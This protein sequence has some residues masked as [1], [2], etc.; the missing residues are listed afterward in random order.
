MVRIFFQTI[1]HCFFLSYDVVYKIDTIY[2]I[3]T[4]TLANNS[5]IVGSLWVMIKNFMH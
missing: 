1:L 3:L 4:S 2:E 5:S